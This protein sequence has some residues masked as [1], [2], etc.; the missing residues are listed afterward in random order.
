MFATMILQGG[1]VPRAL[2]ST[3]CKYIEGGKIEPKLEEVV[4]ITV[5][6]SLKKLQEADTQQDANNAFA[7]CSDWR[8]EIDGLPSSLK[9]ENKDLFL[10]E[11]IEYFVVIKC[12]P[13]LDQLLDRLKYYNVLELL[14]AHKGMAQHIFMYDPDDKLDVKKLLKILKPNLAPIG[15]IRRQSEEIVMAKF[16]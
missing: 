11:V 6:N 8:V 1:E 3:V 5:R 12:K 16:I 15:N 13:M 14:R 7:E 4:E 9:L 2:S 10:K